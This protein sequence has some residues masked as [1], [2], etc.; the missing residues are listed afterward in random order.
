[1]SSDWSTHDFIIDHITNAVY[2]ASEI[3]ASESNTEAKVGGGRAQ[4]D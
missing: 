2:D 1:M 4:T 3:Y